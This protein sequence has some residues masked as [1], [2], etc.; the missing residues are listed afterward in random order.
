MARLLALL[1]TIPG[2]H[3]VV[4]NELVADDEDGTAKRITILEGDELLAEQDPIKRRPPTTPRV[5]HMHP[6]IQLSNFAA[7][8]DVG[9]G[10]SAMR[11]AVIKKIALDAAL[12]AL[13]HDG[14]GGVY[15]GLESDL[16]FARQMEGRAA[17]KFQFAYVLRPDEL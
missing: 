4:R 14:F 15:L 1:Q 7:S 12:I 11:A 9:S 17:L 6:Q 10:L 16:G 3:E 8:S 2:V 13:T 5:M